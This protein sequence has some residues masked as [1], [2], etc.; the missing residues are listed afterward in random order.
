[1][2][3]MSQQANCVKVGG[4][5]GWNHTHYHPCGTRTSMHVS[6]V[7]IKFGGV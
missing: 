6:A 3:R 1:L 5:Y 7:D 4:G 2:L